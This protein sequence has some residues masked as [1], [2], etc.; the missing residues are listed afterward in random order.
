V[1]IFFISFNPLFYPTRCDKLPRE[2][3][4]LVLRVDYVQLT[5]SFSFLIVYPVPIPGAALHAVTYSRP[6]E[7]ILRS[8][9]LYD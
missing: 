5:V 1:V 2:Y 3:R 4:R 9:V 6:L 7:L 8:I